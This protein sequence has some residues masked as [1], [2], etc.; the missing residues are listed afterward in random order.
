VGWFSVAKFP[1]VHGRRVGAEPGGY[2]P[3][4]P[5]PVQPALAEV[6]AD[7]A[8]FSRGILVN[9]LRGTV[10]T[11]GDSDARP[12][13]PKRRP[14][15]ERTLTSAETAWKRPPDRSPALAGAGGV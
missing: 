6:I 10:A 3:L 8:E 5:F 14:R 7:G 13:A 12:L 11:G 1:G 15:R 2:V 4:T 9:R